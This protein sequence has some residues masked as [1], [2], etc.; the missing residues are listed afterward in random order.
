MLNF[1]KKCVG[2]SQLNKADVA[3]NQ[4]ASIFEQSK[5]ENDRFAGKIFPIT[6]EYLEKSV[7]NYDHPGKNDCQLI[8]DMLLKKAQSQDR[9]TSF[10]VHDLPNIL[11]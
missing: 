8:L 6:I 9:L 7:K 3:L 11:K 5:S 4:L 2:F 1:F 10:D